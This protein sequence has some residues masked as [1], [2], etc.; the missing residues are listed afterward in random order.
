MVQD[1]LRIIQREAAKHRQPTIQPQPFTPHQSPRGGRGED[2]GR[3]A[4]D[5]DDGDAGEEGPAEVE[6]FFLLGGRADEGYG[7]HHGDG[8]EAGA[9]EDGGLHEHEGGEDG[10]LAEVEAGPEGVFLYV[11]VDVGFHVSCLVYLL[12]TLG[13]GGWEAYLSGLVLNVPYMVP[14]LAARPTPNTSHGFVV[15]SL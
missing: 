1:L 14:I 4:G 3:E 13:W 15:I 2:E 9:G 10:G 11:A 7:T 5:G 8:V 12:C 6:V